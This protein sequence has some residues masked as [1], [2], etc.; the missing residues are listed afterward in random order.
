MLAQGHRP[1]FVQAH[2]KELNSSNGKI[3]NYPQNIQLYVKGKPRHQR[4]PPNK[5]CFSK[6]R[7]AHHEEFEEILPF[8]SDHNRSYTANEGKE[9]EQKNMNLNNKP[10]FGDHQE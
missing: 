9:N 5:E 10:N 2:G 7:Y 1:K 4:R 3:S 8:Y 6:T